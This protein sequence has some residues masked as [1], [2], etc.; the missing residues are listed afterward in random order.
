MKKELQA[1]EQEPGRCNLSLM[2]WNLAMLKETPT[3]P[4]PQEV[5]IRAKICGHQNETRNPTVLSGLYIFANTQT[6]GLYCQLSRLG[7]FG[8]EEEVDY[9]VRA[10]FGAL[11]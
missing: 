8:L 7:Y 3:V 11:G 10:W 1:K 4:L 5:M 2:T 6:R 9:H